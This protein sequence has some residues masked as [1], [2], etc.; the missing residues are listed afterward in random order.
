MKRALLAT[1]LLGSVLSAAEMTGWISDSSCGAA[2]A[3]SDKGAREC[4]AACIKGGAKAVFVTEKDK[5]VYK[6]ADSSKAV[7]FLEKKVKVSGKISGDTIEI[8]SIAYAE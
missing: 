1:I 5:A 2:N 3:S 6:I 8:T 7:K 4:A